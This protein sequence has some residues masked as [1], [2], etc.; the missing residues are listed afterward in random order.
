MVGAFLNSFF[1]IFELK[2]SIFPCHRTCFINFC[3]FR[4]HFAIHLKLSKKKIRNF[5]LE[6]SLR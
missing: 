5:S 2:N 6:L 4:S 3:K 1:V